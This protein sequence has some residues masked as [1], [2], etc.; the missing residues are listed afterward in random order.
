[1]KTIHII[2]EII[3]YGDVIVVVVCQSSSCKDIFERLF[4]SAANEGCRLLAWC[5][6]VFKELE[7]RVYFHYS[8]HDGQRRGRCLAMTEVARQRAAQRKKSE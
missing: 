7:K 6:L 4:L 2:K 3:E 5:T 8:M 1:M